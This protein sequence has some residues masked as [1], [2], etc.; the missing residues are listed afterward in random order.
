[1]KKGVSPLVAAVLLIAATMS[2]A[3]ILAYWTS[4]F[5]KTTLPDVNQT[6]MECKYAGFKIYQCTYSN[7]SLQLSLT[8]NNYRT[9]E[10]KEMMVY[11]F[12][13][14]GT[15]STGF[16]LNETLVPGEFKT[17]TITSFPQGFSKIVISSLLC[18]EIIP[19][20]ASC[21]RT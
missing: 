6:Q 7:T 10:V 20:E 13:P 14:N 11:A 1:M 9:V 21:T 8:L 5:V 4:G 3:G 15:T 19:E 18:P 17:F 12:F 2:I 16:K